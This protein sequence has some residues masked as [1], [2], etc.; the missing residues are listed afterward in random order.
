[1]KEKY[2]DLFKNISSKFSLSGYTVELAN[3]FL[4]SAHSLGLVAGPD[5]LGS[6]SALL[7]SR[8]VY[9]KNI[10]VCAHMDNVGYIVY[11]KSSPDTIT[12]VPV[13]YPFLSG[14]HNCKL[15]TQDN[16][17]LDLLIDVEP[18]EQYTV[19]TVE[20]SFFDKIN[21]GDYII[22]GDSVVE[23]PRGKFTGPYMDN[24]AG[25]LSVIMAMENIVNAKVDTGYNLFFVLSEFEEIGSYGAIAA[26]NKI[27]PAMVIN[28]DVFPVDDKSSLTNG[29]CISTGPIINRKL[30]EYAV[31]TAKSNNIKYKVCV[32]SPEDETDL[33]SIIALNG[34]TPCCEIGPPCYGLHTM[35]EM[36]SK[37]SLECTALLL[38]KMCLNASS[39]KSLMQ[40]G[41]YA[42]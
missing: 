20:D 13:G 5:L 3:I 21:I 32:S 38:T 42:M 11:E 41:Y 7:K 40:G 10:M 29:V 37:S 9:A 1:M 31:N 34:G 23:A 4:E 35:D 19:L 36:V 30:F 2:T 15:R 8:N 17:I 27:N 16:E 33:N 25:V 26:A 28:V 12:I 6:V 14:E 18:E 39:V 22:Y 24:R